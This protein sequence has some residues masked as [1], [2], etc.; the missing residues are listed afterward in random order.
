M[1]SGKESLGNFSDHLS[2][3]LLLSHNFGL[4]GGEVEHLSK[5]VSELNVVLSPVSLKSSSQV[6]LDGNTVDEN[7]VLKGLEVLDWVSGD[8]VS[9]IEL[10][11]VEG[12]GVDS[13]ASWD[14]FLELLNSSDACNNSGDSIRSSRLNISV[15]DSGLELLYGNVEHE[16]G[17]IFFVNAY[18]E[19][20]KIEISSISFEEALLDLSKLNFVSRMSHLDK[21]FLTEKSLGSGFSDID[22]EFLPVS[23]VVLSGSIFEF[24][25]DLNTVDHEVLTNVIDEAHW[26]GKDLD[27]SLKLLNIQSD[28]FAVTDGALDMLE[29]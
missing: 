17:L 3:V 1:G 29:H 8:I 26:A 21:G 6:S 5:E 2:V 12:G 18:K 28:A 22:T 11:V 13:F 25:V 16:K 10:L 9:V 23:N 27:H 14:S 7:V 15:L 4:L 24:M 19:S 20:I